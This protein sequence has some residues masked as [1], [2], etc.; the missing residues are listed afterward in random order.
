MT[1]DTVA[2]LRLIAARSPRAADRAL[3]AIRA[4]EVRS[5]VLATRLLHVVRDALR[6][7]EAEWT[8]DERAQIAALIAV[9]DAA[10][11]DARRTLADLLATSG[12]TPTELSRVLGR[13]DRTMRRWLSGEQDVPDTLARQVARLRVT[14]VDPEGVHLTYTR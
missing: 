2:T 13:D 9:P 1:N 10:S 8:P 6:D 7:T 3:T 14:A 4:A 11:E 5:P 12:L